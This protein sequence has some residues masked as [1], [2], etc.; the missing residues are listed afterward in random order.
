MTVT[1]TL[2]PIIKRGAMPEYLSTA[3]AAER[4]QVSY[5]TMARWIRLGHF[6]NARKKN[7]FLETSPYII[8]IEDIENFEHGKRGKKK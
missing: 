4:L 6:P 7:P 1:V 8:P 3:D 5:A 2:N